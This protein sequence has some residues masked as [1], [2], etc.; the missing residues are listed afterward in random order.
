VPDTWKYSGISRLF[1]QLAL[2]PLAFSFLMIMDYVLMEF[3]INLLPSFE[4]NCLA[5]YLLRKVTEMEEKLMQTSYP[6]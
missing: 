3:I 6:R 4:P 1:S 5:V 2:L